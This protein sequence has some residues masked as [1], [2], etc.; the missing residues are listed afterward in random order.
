MGGG[1]SE[2]FIRGN[3]FSQTVMATNNGGSVLGCDWFVIDVHVY[4][5]TGFSNS[6][7]FLY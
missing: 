1:K 3:Y 4:V 2:Y 6:G 7:C 5:N